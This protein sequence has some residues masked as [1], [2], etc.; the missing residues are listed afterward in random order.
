MVPTLNLPAPQTL[1]LASHIIDRLIELMDFVVELMVAGRA[2][3]VMLQL[4]VEVAVVLQTA[5]R[6]IPS[7]TRTLP[8]AFGFRQ[9]PPSQTGGTQH[10]ARHGT[11]Q[12]STA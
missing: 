3:W 7:L 6:Q 10:G 5:E 4:F 1:E 12:H 2:R 9:Q 8:A 11:Q